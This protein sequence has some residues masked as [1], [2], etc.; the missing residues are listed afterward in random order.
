MRGC[1]SEMTQ[2]GGGGDHVN[3]LHSHPTTLHGVLLNLLTMDAKIGEPVRGSRAE[4][5]K[6]KVPRPKK[7]VQRRGYGAEWV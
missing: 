1:I 4:S 5:F 2:T 3:T 7:R 6:L